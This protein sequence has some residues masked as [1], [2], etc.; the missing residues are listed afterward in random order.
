M[1]LIVRL[2]GG[3]GEM[4]G[5]IL[6]EKELQKPECLAIGRILHRGNGSPRIYYNVGVRE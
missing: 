5:N 6:K 1:F 4:V 3:H 2:Q